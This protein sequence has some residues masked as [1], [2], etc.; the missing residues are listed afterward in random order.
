MANGMFLEFDTR[1]HAVVN[2]LGL[3][4]KRV[5]LLRLEKHCATTVLP[6][7]ACNLAHLSPDLYSKGSFL[8]I[9]Y[10]FGTGSYQMSSSK[11]VLNPDC[12][13]QNRE[14]AKF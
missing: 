13:V 1:H 6:S 9:I 14:V 5:R 2:L 8:R 10:N 12:A 11:L 4:I 3:P 7:P